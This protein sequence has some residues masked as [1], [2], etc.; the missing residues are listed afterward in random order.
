[1]E[2]ARIISDQS[3]Q[4]SHRHTLRFIA[5]AAE[6]YHPKHDGYHHLGSL[7]DALNLYTSQ[8]PVAAVLILDMIAFNPLN[9]YI[10]IITNTQSLWL[11]DSVATMADLYVPALQTNSRPFPDVS[12][13]DHDSYQI[14]GFPAILLMENDRPWAD[15]LPYYQLNPNYHTTADII[16]TLRFSQL[17]KVT[18]LA[19][20][21][22]LHL[23]GSGGITSINRDQSAS[24]EISELSVY[25]NPFNA[26]TTISFTLHS[27]ASISANIY[28]VRGARVKQL[29]TQSAPAN[30]I[31]Y[32][33]NGTDNT[34]HAVGSGTYFL[35][36]EANPQILVKKIVLLK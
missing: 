17:T 16:S 18:Q 7:Y 21:S 24:I 27:A 3:Q 33:W 14:Y 26:T 2:M 1:M 15:D 19:L 32:T 29:T 8:T 25:P 23:S 5:L 20:A 12:Y 6:E 36:V 4:L 35:I 13:S 28:D 34:G 9:D 11:A 31:N 10:E 30:R 22:I